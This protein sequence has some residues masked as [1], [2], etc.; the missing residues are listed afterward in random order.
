VQWS[1]TVLDLEKAIVKYTRYFSAPEL[2]Q[3]KGRSEQIS[4]TLLPSDKPA[5]GQLTHL[6]R[7]NDTSNMGAG[8]GGR[9]AGKHV[10]RVTQGLGVDGELPP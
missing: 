8:V 4:I 6:L 2:F 3:S 1:S 9:E 5:E 10:L 7:E